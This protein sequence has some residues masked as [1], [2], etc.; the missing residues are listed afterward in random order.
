MRNLRE[1]SFEALQLT[2]AHAE[3]A[4]D[5]GEDDAADDENDD[6]YDRHVS[7]AGQVGLH[8]AALRLAVAHHLRHVLR[9]GQAL[10]RGVL[11]SE[12]TRTL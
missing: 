3:E 8:H 6:E 10:A 7:G 12:K 9:H 4:D 2:Q 1:G 5:G 11:A